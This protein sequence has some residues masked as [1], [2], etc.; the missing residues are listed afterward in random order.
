M[1]PSSRTPEGRPNQCPICGH[2]VIIEPSQGSFDATCPH[3]GCLL[4]FDGTGG[5]TADRALPDRDRIEQTKR[6]IRSLV[7]EVAQFSRSDL[8]EE[9]FYSQFLPRVVSAL[10]AV[11]G[12]VWTLNPEGRLALQYQINIQETKLRDSEEQQAQHG[13]LLYKVLSGGEALLAPPNVGRGDLAHAHGEAPA[14]NPTAFL[15]LLG[16]LR[17]EVENVGVVEIFQRPESTPTTQKGYLRFLMQMCE[18][19]NDFLKRL[20]KARTGG[21]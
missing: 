10:A 3:C 19:A 12:A 5:L 2:R 21:K 16:L 18:L 17:T 15:L 20:G 7:A 9:E 6:Q 4:W 13:R 11:G 1:E 8:T 14:A